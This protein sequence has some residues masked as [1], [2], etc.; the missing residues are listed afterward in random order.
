MPN[1]IPWRAQLIFIFIIWPLCVP[2]SQRIFSHFKR[3]FCIHDAGHT[4]MAAQLNFYDK[5][6]FLLFSELGGMQKLLRIALLAA[7]Q[8]ES[9]SVYVHICRRRVERCRKYYSLR[10]ARQRGINIPC[11]GPLFAITQKGA[12]GSITC[13][14]A[15][16]SRSAEKCIIYMHFVIYYPALDVD[17]IKLNFRNTP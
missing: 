11:R 7:F 4:L 9:S 6:D 3:T 1:S 10:L 8:L 2:C 16:P 13:T 17:K 15:N 5:S 12:R 14:R